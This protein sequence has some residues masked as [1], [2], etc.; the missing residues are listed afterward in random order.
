[1]QQEHSLTNHSQ[2]ST[3]AAPSSPKPTGNRPKSLP[4]LQPARSRSHRLPDPKRD[5]QRSAHHH[6]CPQQRRANRK[7]LAHPHRDRSLHRA[8]WRQV[9]RDRRRRHPAHRR[10]PAHRGR[11]RCARRR[12]QSQRG[13]RG[14]DLRRQ[15]GGL[16]DGNG[17]VYF[18]G[19]Q[20]EYGRLGQHAGGE[21]VCH[22]GGDG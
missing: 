21:F 10:L 15:H 3:C 16:P 7:R 2:I 14:A 19:H 9:H 5:R 20:H 11:P 22:C 6:L 8:Q 1:M 12:H 4:H 17:R 18:R 13:Q